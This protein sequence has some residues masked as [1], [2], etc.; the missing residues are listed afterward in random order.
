MTLDQAERV[1]DTCL[2]C[3]GATQALFE[4]KQARQ[5]GE[6]TELDVVDAVQDYLEKFRAFENARNTM[7]VL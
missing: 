1:I 7:G 4:V 2:E 6:A 5:R 3:A